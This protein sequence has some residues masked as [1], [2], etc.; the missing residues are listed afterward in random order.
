M[1]I[2][3]F[4]NVSKTYR[5][6]EHDRKILDSINLEIHAGEFI[7]LVGKLGAGKTTLTNLI[8]GT[9]KPDSGTV[10][11][12]GS[13]IQS[14]GKRRLGYMHQKLRSP[15]RLKIEEF[16]EL[17]RSYYDQP[18]SLE[19]LLDRSQLQTKRGDWADSKELS[20][21]QERKLHYALAIAGNPEFLI[22]DEPTPALDTDFKA[23]LLCQLKEFV[24]QKKTILLITQEQAVV[25]ELSPLAT[26]ILQLKDGKLQALKETQA[27]KE[28]DLTKLPSISLATQLKHTT[29]AFIGQTK[30]ELLQMLRQPGLLLS[31]LFLYCT[32]A[33]IPKGENAFSSMIGIAGG[34]LLVT[35]TQTF[36]V[37]IATER[38]QGWLRLL[39]AT[40]LPP[41]IYIASKI[42]VATFISTLGLLIAFGL[43]IFKL[44][45]EQPVLNWLALSF[46]LLVGVLPFA[47][48]GFAIAHLF[49][50]GII[51][52]ISMGIFALAFFSSGC[53]PLPEMPLWLQDLIPFSPFYHYAQ[54]V[55]WAS[56]PEEQYNQL[57]GLHLE[58]LIWTA[59]ATGSLASWAYKRDRA[60]G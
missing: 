31:I 14:P 54:L 56:A 51:S 38:K 60:F 48:L 55:I 17:Y 30:V 26:R 4:E 20:G 27:L 41:W 42:A 59:C 10:L 52:L 29:D 34:G 22:L 5:E 9:E 25:E 53:L 19:E 57:L 33:L 58:W 6:G 36:G 46:C 40:P 7:L 24:S 49:E 15:E 16:I 21:G 3:T 35:V 28:A 2:V 47:L 50:A 32:V 12:F 18:F 45:I 11:L 8:M 44:G 13:P 37:Q 1:N 39:R 23:A 43:G